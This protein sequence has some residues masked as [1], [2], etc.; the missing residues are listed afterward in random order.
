MCV[1]SIK[2]PIRKKAGNLSNALCVYIYIYACVC[3]LYMCI[4]MCVSVYT[5]SVY[6]YM[7]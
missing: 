1:L 6:D 4:C 7:F 3:V 2:V 5:F